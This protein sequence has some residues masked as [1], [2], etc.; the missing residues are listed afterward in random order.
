MA[1]P[2]MRAPYS[3]MCET[4]N[5]AADAAQPFH[6]HP[7]PSTHPPTHQ[8]V[9]EHPLAGDR[10][11]V[12]IVADAA[13]ATEAMRVGVQRHSPLPGDRRSHLQGRHVGGGAMGRQSEDV[14][15]VRWEGG[16]RSTAGTFP[17]PKSY[18]GRQ[19]A[20]SSAPSLTHPPPSSP[21]SPAHCPLP[22]PSPP[23]LVS[24]VVLGWAPVED[25]HKRAAL[26]HQHLGIGG[27]GE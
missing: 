14:P 1:F 8:P 4:V 15:C 19:S 26:K 18:F 13:A 20:S 22:S 11:M 3:H 7:T 16:R 12:D 5:I 23:H 24:L 21:F 25:K 6:A 17:S 2:S 10:E 9:V 27:A